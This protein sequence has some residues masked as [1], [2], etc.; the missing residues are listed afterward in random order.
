MRTPRIGLAL[1]AG[2]IRG[3]AHIGVL[4]V[5]EK[6]GIVFDLV[7]GTSIGSI[8]GALYACG[9]TPGEMEN[10]ALSLSERQ[11]A[12]IVVPRQ[13]FLAGRRIEALVREWTHHRQFEDTLIPFAAVACAFATMEQVVLREGPLSEAV[14][15]SISIPGIFIPVEKDGVKLVDGGILRRI[16]C[17]VIREMGA[18]VIIGVDVGY[19]G[20]KRE[21]NTVIEHVIHA[22]DIFEW[23]VARETIS[24]AHVMISPDTADIDPTR[25]GKQVAG[26]IERGREAALRALPDVQ[27]A[28]SAFESGDEVPL[29]SV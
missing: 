24:E 17:D 27:R 20:S 13:G 7:A 25:L 11:I 15:A 5:F 21:T 14:R 2:G 6:E 1:G 29:E 10:L 12:D 28:I 4:S 16:P 22:I 3:L 19:K 23:L 8:V 9:M 26:C 18:D